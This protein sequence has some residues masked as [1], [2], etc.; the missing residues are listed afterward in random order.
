MN[1]A[2]PA[3]KEG[4]KVPADYT[5]LVPL[6]VYIA[7]PSHEPHLWF[8]PNLVS[9]SPQFPE[10]EL[11]GLGSYTKAMALK[12]FCAQSRKNGMSLSL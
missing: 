1:D 8:R 7:L 2:S 5:G 3:L 11:S 12:M 9:L 10:L 4:L 6:A